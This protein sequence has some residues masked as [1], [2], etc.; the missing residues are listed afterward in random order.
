MI[1]GKCNSNPIRLRGSKQVKC[2]SCGLESMVNMA[3]QNLCLDCSDKYNKCQSCGEEFAK[4]EM[5]WV[6]INKQ[7]E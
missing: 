4:A 5:D 1:C 2:I 7:G 6:Y 3:Y